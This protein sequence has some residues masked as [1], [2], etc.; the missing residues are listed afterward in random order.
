[1]AKQ[2]GDSGRARPDQA[3]LSGSAVMVAALTVRSNTIMHTK[4]S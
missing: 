4:A 1:M 3:G 2:V